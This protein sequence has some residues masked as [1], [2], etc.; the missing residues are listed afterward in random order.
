MTYL[1]REQYSQLRLFTCLSPARRCELPKVEQNTRARE[2]TRRPTHTRVRGSIYFQRLARTRPSVIF[3][4][5]TFRA[6][7]VKRLI[8]SN[9]LLA[10]RPAVLLAARSDATRAICHGSAGLP[11]FIPRLR[12]ATLLAATTAFRILRVGRTASPGYFRPA[13]REPPDPAGTDRSRIE[14]CC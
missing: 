6:T 1:H 7:R 8:R 4:H 10:R 9:R 13:S 12:A 3:I 5:E 14:L 11:S 2:C